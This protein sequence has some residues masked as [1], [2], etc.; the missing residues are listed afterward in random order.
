MKLLEVH[1]YT[2]M[3]F[4]FLRIIRVEVEDGKGG[5]YY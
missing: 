4:V 5:Y 1:K 2:D 3:A